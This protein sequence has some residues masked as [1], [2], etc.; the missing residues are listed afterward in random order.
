MPLRLILFDLDGTL[1]DTRRDLAEAVNHTLREMSLPEKPLKEL[2]RHVG[3]GVRGLLEEAVAATGGHSIDDTLSRFKGHYL[4]GLVHHTRLY[5]GVDEVLTASA[6]LH[7]AIVTNKSMVYTEGVVAGLALTDR[8]E[9]VLGGDST[10]HMKP[11]PAMLQTALDHFQVAPEEALMVGDG[12]PDVEAAQALGIPC[13]LLTCGMGDPEALAAA[14]PDHLWHHISE[15][16][17]HLS[18]PQE[19]P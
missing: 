8:I 4:R 17:P 9:L 5:D 7:R 1:A 6:H 18:E 11:H 3:Q 12:L 2:Y 16:L 19:Q 10:P 15:L 13:A 14:R